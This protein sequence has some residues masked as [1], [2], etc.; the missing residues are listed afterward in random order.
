[1]DCAHVIASVKALKVR[2][3]CAFG[4]FL[5]IYH[6]RGN[7]VLFDVNIQSRSRWGNLSEIIEDVKYACEFDDLHPPSGSRW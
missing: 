2:G 3:T 5:V 4:K 6:S 1:M 7:Y